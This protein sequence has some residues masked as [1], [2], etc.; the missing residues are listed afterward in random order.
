MP[1]YTNQ[2]QQ[3]PQNQ[4][5]N[6][7]AAN[8]NNYYNRADGKDAVVHNMQTEDK[9]Q[10]KAEAPPGKCTTYNQNDFV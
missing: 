2:S 9:E 3:N 8:P 4:N 5:Q 1:V 6:H 10:M 7:L